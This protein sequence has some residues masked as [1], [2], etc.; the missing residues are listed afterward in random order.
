MNK[1]NLTVLGS[2]NIPSLRQQVRREGSKSRIPYNQ[3]RPLNLHSSQ[4]I[5]RWDPQQVTPIS[6]NTPDKSDSG[7]WM[8][9]LAKRAHP[10]LTSLWGSSSG[11]QGTLKNSIMWWRCRWQEDVTGKQ[12][13]SFHQALELY[14]Y[15]L[16]ILFSPFRRQSQDNT[17]RQLKL[18][19]IIIKKILKHLQL[20]T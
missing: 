15:L 20:C 10:H 8:L 7:S 11:L 13:W 14:R 17:N 1:K 4:W 18:I 6:H 19:I 9:N 3:Q 16:S 12:D 2:K 5:L